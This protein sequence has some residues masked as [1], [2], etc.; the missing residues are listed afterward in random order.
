MSSSVR[1]G[2]GIPERCLNPVCGKPV[3]A[4][5]EGTWR[6]TPRQFCSKECKND[7][8]VLRRAAALLKPLGGIK[9]SS[10]LIEFWESGER[11]TGET[12]LAGTIG[13]KG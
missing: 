7:A 4:I 3:E 13:G 8:S 11:K 1:L 2:A 5:A 10:V 9:A 12:K 6:R